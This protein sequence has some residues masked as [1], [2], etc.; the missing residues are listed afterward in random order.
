MLDRTGSGRFPGNTKPTEHRGEK[1]VGGG[2][3]REGEIVSPGLVQ[4]TYA[5]IKSIYADDLRIRW[6]EKTEFFQY[7]FGDLMMASFLIELWRGMYGVAP[8]RENGILGQTDGSPFP[9]FVDIACGSGVL[10]Y[11][12]LM[13]GYEGCGFDADRRKTWSIF[14]GW[15]QEKLMERYLVPQPFAD[16]LEDEDIGV[17][18]HTGKFPNDTFIISNHADELTVWTPLMAALACPTS[19]LPFLIIPCCSH[20]LTGAP[21]RHLPQKCEEENDRL[22]DNADKQNESIEQNPQPA[23]GDLKALR[24][25]KNHEKTAEGSLNSTYGSLT[26]KIMEIAAEIGYDVEKTQ[27]PIPSPRN[28][29]VLGNRQRVTNQWKRRPKSPSLTSTATDEDEGKG[30]ELSQK[31]MDIVDR[32]CARDGGRQASAQTWVAR[33]Q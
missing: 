18:F 25:A 27:V 5:R 12:L 14:P 16:A 28:T 4:N 30:K 3:P 2:N 19:P 13:E 32:E 20:S 22:K 24:A 17:D 11:V 21:Y 9:G 29:G 7:V 33:T 10:V 8:A 31:I 15:V 1:D 23:A 6:V 26:A